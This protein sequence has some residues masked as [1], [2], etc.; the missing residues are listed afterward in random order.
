MQL[1]FPVRTERLTIRPL[2]LED[3]DRHFSIFSNPDVV[4]YL[5]EEPLTPEQAREHLK[6][7]CIL[8]LPNEGAW[9][10]F[11]VELNKDGV[12]VGEIG[13]AHISATHGHYEVGYVFDPA[14]SGH[15]YATEA[16]AIV[17]ELA[18]SGLSAHR[19]TGRLDARNTRSAAVLERLGMRR[20]GHFV[21]N[22]FV[23]G[24]WT[25]EVVY[26]VLEDEWRDLRGP[27]PTFHFRP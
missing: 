10:N 9:V 26:A 25:D 11:G 14:Y 15:G 21:E 20:E 7:R 16:A 13:M 3:F 2:S 4:R 19:V 12:L 27:A 6:R 1:V 17:I 8:D 23:K 24:E 22:E 18:I 5:Y